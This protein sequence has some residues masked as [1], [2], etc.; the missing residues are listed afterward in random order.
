MNGTIIYR[1]E[2]ESTISEAINGRWWSV[3]TAYARQFLGDGRDLMQR[4]FEFDRCCDLRE[5]LASDGAVSV[6]EFNSFLTRNGVEIPENLREGGS[7]RIDSFIIQ[8]FLDWDGAAFA[9]AGFE[10][11]IHAEHGNMQEPAVLIF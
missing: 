5:C 11:V 9:R 2:S 6:D 7:D 10:A 8:E 1:G 3:D 4:V